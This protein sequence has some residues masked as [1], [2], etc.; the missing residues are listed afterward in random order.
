MPWCVIT[1]E[2]RLWGE[3]ALMSEADIG[4]MRRTLHAMKSGLEVLEVSE[5][6]A[7]RIHRENKKTNPSTRRGWKYSFDPI[8]YNSARYN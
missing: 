5:A 2:G 7:V 4:I 3:A 6:D 8:M 1:N